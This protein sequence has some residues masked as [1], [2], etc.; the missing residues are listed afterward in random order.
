MDEEP[1]S[2]NPI[3]QLVQIMVVVFLLATTAVFFSYGV[4]VSSMSQQVAATGA[5]VPPLPAQKPS[6][7]APAVPP[8][9]VSREEATGCPKGAS[10]QT[11]QPQEVKPVGDCADPKASPQIKAECKQQETVAKSQ[12]ARCTQGEK[13]SEVCKP[14]EI[15]KVVYT[16][17]S[18]FLKSGETIV[19]CK[20][21]PTPECPTVSSTTGAL[22][23]WESKD[24]N[25]QCK[26]GGEENNKKP[27]D[28]SVAKNTDDIA[29]QV[30]GTEEGQGGGSGSGGSPSGG[31]QSPQDEAIAQAF[32]DPNTPPLPGQ[33]SEALKQHDQELSRQIEQAG[34]ALDNY[35]DSDVQNL[36]EERRLNENY[37]RLVQERAELAPYVRQALL[38]DKQEIDANPS[39]SSWPSERQNIDARISELDRLVQDWGTMSQS[40][41]PESAIRAQFLDD[42]SRRVPDSIRRALDETNNPGNLRRTS[43]YPGV[44]TSCSHGASTCY[45]T[46]V[47]GAAANM[48]QYMRRIEQGYNTPERLINL[49]SPSHDNNNPNSIISDVVRDTGVCRT[50]TFDIQNPSQ[51]AGL[52]NATTRHEY[53]WGPGYAYSYTDIYGAELGSMYL[54]Q[55]YQRALEY[56]AGG[57]GLGPTSRLAR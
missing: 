12:I 46:P 36:E 56:R 55:G 47:D 8:P 16:S 27:D 9:P 51:M 17:K 31:G 13:K 22:C 37:E 10:C 40:S 14:Y 28:T 34:Q 18:C 29:K 20:P 23:T 39:A 33:K 26:K 1:G 43:Q 3:E 30:S 44:S 21:K 54:A 50:C 57:Y 4:N 52:L 25:C 38:D 15:S 5:S 32:E 2:K 45:Q 49:M 41:D 19:K 53:G 11:S 35:Y 42:E 7:P 6:A 48:A 24:P